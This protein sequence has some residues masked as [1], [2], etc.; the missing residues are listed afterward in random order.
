MLVELEV[1][2]RQA[3]LSA[4]VHNGSSMGPDRGWLLRSSASSVTSC[5]VARRQLMAPDK[6]MP[7]KA[8]YRINASHSMDS[9]ISV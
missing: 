6:P 2:R 7:G 1:A 9:R 3:S 4:D 5:P 8:L